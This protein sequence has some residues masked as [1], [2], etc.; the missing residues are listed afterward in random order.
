MEHHHGYDYLYLNAQIGNIMK[1]N[2]NCWSTLRWPLG[3]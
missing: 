2:L 1:A 3:Q